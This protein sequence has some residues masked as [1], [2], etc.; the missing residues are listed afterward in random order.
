MLEG[1]FSLADP[2]PAECESL[3]LSFTTTAVVVLVAGATI[4]LATAREYFR[5]AFAAA[6]RRAGLLPAFVSA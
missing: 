4:V 1:L 5:R 2:E 6:N 3:A